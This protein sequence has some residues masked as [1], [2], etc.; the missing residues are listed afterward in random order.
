L[1]TTVVATVKGVGADQITSLVEAFFES[2]P[3]FFACH[4]LE[5]PE[6]GLKANVKGYRKTGGG[7]TIVARIKSAA[8][9]ATEL[10]IKGMSYPLF[11]WGSTKKSVMLVVQCLREEYPSLEVSAL[12]KEHKVVGPIRI[13]G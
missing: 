5:P 6:Q 4:R 8:P 1:I 12:T 11:D 7:E 2:N 3:H 9:S 13:V 10:E